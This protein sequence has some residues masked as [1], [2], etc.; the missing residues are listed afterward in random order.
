MNSSVPTALNSVSFLFEMTICL[1]SQLPI[2]NYQ[3]PIIPVAIA[4]SPFPIPSQKP[5]APFPTPLELPAGD[6]A[7]YSHQ[8]PVPLQ[9]QPPRGPYTPTPCKLQKKTRLLNWR[10]STS[11]C[12]KPASNYQHRREK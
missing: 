8:K 1:Y 7:P 4:T 12:E 9:T 10:C 3:L 6:R 11:A 5:P 2:T